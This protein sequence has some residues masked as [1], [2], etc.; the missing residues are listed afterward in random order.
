MALRLS[1]GLGRIAQRQTGL[2]ERNSPE[3]QAGQGA[4]GE[5]VR[6][7]HKHSLK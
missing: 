1:E 5:V 3:D 2:A 6:A 4:D 7:K